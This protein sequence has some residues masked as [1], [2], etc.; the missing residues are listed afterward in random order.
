MDLLNGLTF[1]ERAVVAE[2]FKRR[3]GSWA[4]MDVEL[5]ARACTAVEDMWELEHQ[6][7]RKL[8]SRMRL[9]GVRRR[10]ELTAE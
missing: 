9:R 2:E 5:L 4:K 10:L 7:V 6:G 1:A 3:G 8:A